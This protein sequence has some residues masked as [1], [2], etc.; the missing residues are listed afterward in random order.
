MPRHADTTTEAFLSA[1]GVLCDQDTS[2]SATPL[3]YTGNGL[4]FQGIPLV[5]DGPGLSLVLGAA[6]PPNSP[7]T[8]LSFPLAPTLPPLLINSPLN[9]L[10]LASGYPIRDDNTSF[11]AYLGS[12]DG[13]TPP[14]QFLAF[15][16]ASDIQSILPGSPGVLKNQ[17]TAQYCRIIDLDRAIIAP[18]A[19]SG[20]S[21]ARAPPPHQHNRN[22]PPSAT[23]RKGQPSANH[24]LSNSGSKMSSSKVLSNTTSTSKAASSA[25]AGMNVLSSPPRSSRPSPPPPFRVRPSLGVPPT[26]AAVTTR[27]PLPT[28][29][30]PPAGVVGPRQSGLRGVA[31][32]QPTP[33]TASIFVYTGTEV[34]YNGMTMIPTGP[35]QVLVL[36]GS[37]KPELAVR[38]A[39]V[40]FVNLTSGALYNLNA[41]ELQL[42]MAGRLGPGLQQP[43]GL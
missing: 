36:D 35:F 43:H 14:E 34:T 3:T 23:G 33:A 24:T 21:L 18:S 29:S 13:T 6:T 12:G 11:P 9:I 16:I 7:P 20:N 15:G 30:S 31:C 27:T 40:P 25:T 32:D 37:R 41:G 17:Q 2:G 19:T 5:A 8:R 10:D 42:A 22:P 4:E 28:V 39:A 1:A 26:A 38:P